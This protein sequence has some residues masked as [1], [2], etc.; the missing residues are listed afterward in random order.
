MQ[1]DY[2]ALEGNIGAGKTTLAN[3]LAEEYNARL[4]LEQFADNPFLPKFY[5][6]PEKHAFPLEMS[7]LAERYQQLKELSSQELFKSTTVSDYYINKSLIFAQSNLSGDEFSLFV[8]LFRIMY[9]MLPRP[10]LLV[11]L[12]LDVD[13]LQSNIRKRGRDY[14]Q[15]IPDQYLIDINSSY[16]EYIRKLQ[17]QRVL[18]IDTNNIDFVKNK[19]DYQKIKSMIMKDWEVGVHRVVL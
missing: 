15:N 2:I 18:I 8:K 3:M 16:F 13:H 4:I 11:Y 7:F 14:E 9:N 17:G 19:S 12:Y 6:D 10:D 1:Y 5:E